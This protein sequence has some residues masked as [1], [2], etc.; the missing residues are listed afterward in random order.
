MQHPFVYD[1]FDG[2]AKPIQGCHGWI[3]W[4]L[5]RNTH[6][7]NLIFMIIIPEKRKET[8]PKK[9]TTRRQRKRYIRC[10]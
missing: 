10:T 8:W 7:E 1:P 9:T 4:A 3:L 5:D 2:D 6:N